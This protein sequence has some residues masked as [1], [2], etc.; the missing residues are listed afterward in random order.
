MKYLLILDYAFI[1]LYFF[2]FK[3]NKTCIQNTIYQNNKKNIFTSY[4]IFSY[5]YIKIKSIDVKRQRYYN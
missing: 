3:K 2:I 5:I 1:G 4:Y